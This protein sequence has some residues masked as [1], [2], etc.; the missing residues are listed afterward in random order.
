MK[1]KISFKQRNRLEGIFAFPKS[2]VDFKYIFVA[3]LFRKT[4]QYRLF[5][6]GQ[7]IMVLP[8]FVEKHLFIHYQTDSLKQVS[9][10]NQV[11]PVPL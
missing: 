3:H 6:K 4:L 7:T 1:P 11:H 8:H 5:G 9:A 2:P 10:Q